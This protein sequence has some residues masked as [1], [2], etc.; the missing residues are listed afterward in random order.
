MGDRTTWGEMR[1]R[2]MA[3][4]TARGAYE[5]ARR[6]HELGEAIRSERERAG[7]SQRELAERMKSTQPVVARLESGAVT[8]TLDTLDRV[9]AALGIELLVQLRPATRRPPR[10]RAAS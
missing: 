7:L 3:S 10:Q 8:P 2:R 5:R 6:A 1:R 4:A 9:A